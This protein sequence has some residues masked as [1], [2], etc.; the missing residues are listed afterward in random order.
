MVPRIPVIRV[1]IP[2]ILLADSL[3]AFFELNSKVEFDGVLIGFEFETTTQHI[4]EEAQ[5]V[6]DWAVDELEED[7]TDH[8]GRENRGVDI[9][10]EGESK[11]SIQVWVVQELTEQIEEHKS[12]DLS[13]RDQA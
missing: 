6:L 9:V 3:E 11:A 7:Q 4:E 2:E 13:N 8:C 1:H 5:H 10:G 12:M